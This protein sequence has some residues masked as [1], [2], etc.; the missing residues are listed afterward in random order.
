METVNKFHQIL[1]YIMELNIQAQKQIA[2]LANEFVII[3]FL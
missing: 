3:F 1:S 2:Q